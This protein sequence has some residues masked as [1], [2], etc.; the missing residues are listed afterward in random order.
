M[1]YRHNRKM[2]RLKAEKRKRCSRRNAHRQSCGGGG[3]RRGGGAGEI[4]S[5]VKTSKRCRRRK[6]KKWRIGEMAKAKIMAAWRGIGNS[7]AALAKAAWRNGVSAIIN[8]AVGI[9]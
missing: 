5:S 4:I 6:S 9:S 7:G 1:K 8:G 2:K 3:I